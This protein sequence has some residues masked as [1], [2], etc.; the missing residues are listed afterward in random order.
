MRMTRDKMI[1]KKSIMNGVI[2][3]NNRINCKKFMLQSK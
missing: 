3:S 1:M 2:M